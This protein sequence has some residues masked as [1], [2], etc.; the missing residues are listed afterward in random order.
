MMVVIGIEN[1]MANQQSS[2]LILDF[3]KFYFA[4]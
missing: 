3:L 4:A 2:K 1:V